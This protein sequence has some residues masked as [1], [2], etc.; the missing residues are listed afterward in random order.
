MGFFGAARGWGVCGGRGL[1]NSSPSLKSVTHILQWWN[2]AQL[3]LTKRRSKKYMNHVTY[4]LSSA[5]S[6]FF[7]KSANFVI[8][9]NKEIDNTL[10]FW[11]IFSNL[12]ESLKIVL[13]NMGKILMMSRKIATPG[14]LKVK[15]FWNKGFDVI[16][17]IHD[18]PNKI[19]SGDSSYT[20]D[21]VMWP[22][23]GNS[24]ISMREVVTISIS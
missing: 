10:A 20:V 21:V 4:P 24:S 11:Y 14:L 3:Y 16:I 7:R 15:L 17:S 5:D 19:L 8:L 22:K 1:L 13:I 23:F 9:R 12:L 18:D 6:I 2:L